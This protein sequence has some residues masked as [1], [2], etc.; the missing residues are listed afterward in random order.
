MIKMMKKQVKLQ[1]IIDGMEMQFD[2]TNTYLNLQTGEVIQVSNDDL[3]TAEEDEPIDHLSDWEQEN[4]KIA[5]DVLDHF[6]NYKELPTKFEMNEYGMM[7]DFCF[8]LNNQR[9]KDIMLSSIQGKGAF[10]RF[11]DN[12]NQLGIEEEWY[13]YQQERYKQIAIEWCKDNDIELI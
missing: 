2:E 10:R 11:K 13:A 9:S 3:R 6:E 4:L 7:E 5:I 1:D 8:T 12:I